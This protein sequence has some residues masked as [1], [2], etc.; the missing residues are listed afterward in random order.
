MLTELGIHV[1]LKSCILSLDLNLVRAT[2]VFILLKIGIRLQTKSGAEI[3][4]EIHPAANKAMS[5]LY[6]LC[7]NLG[8]AN[9]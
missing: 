6:V 8:G 2:V 7:H 3:C 9:L 1:G 4:L 5:V